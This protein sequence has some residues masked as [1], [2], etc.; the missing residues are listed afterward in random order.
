[1]CF[2]HSPEIHVILPACPL[3]LSEMAIDRVINLSSVL[4]CEA[5]LIK[6]RDTTHKFIDVIPDEIT[7]KSQIKRYQ[8]RVY[9]SSKIPVLRPT[10]TTYHFDFL[11]PG[12]ET[13]R[14]GVGGSGRTDVDG[15]ESEVF[16]GVTLLAEEADALLL[17]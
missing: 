9:Q 12:V 2:R 13:R 3:N 8:E 5:A 17:V 7:S 14:D 4:S 1:M 10:N 11:A 6:P 16:E 15:Q